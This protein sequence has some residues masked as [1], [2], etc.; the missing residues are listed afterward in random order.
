MTDIIN[1]PAYPVPNAGFYG[2]RL[3][4]YFAAKLL[5]SSFSHEKNQ[6]CLGAGDTH[7]M[8]NIAKDC[9]LM[10]DIMMEARQK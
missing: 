4:D 3:R 5:I 9:Y 8:N 2:M 7:S 6:V 1:E 10:A